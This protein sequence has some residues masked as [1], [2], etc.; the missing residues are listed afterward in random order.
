MNSLQRIG[1]RM[2]GRGSASRRVDVASGKG[3]P[4]SNLEIISPATA[5]KRITNQP[6]LTQLG[7]ASPM[8]E[9]DS[10]VGSEEKG[11]A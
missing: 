10:F 5:R 2:W 9:T 8:T 3:T 4:M 7:R 6:S 11:R 1:R